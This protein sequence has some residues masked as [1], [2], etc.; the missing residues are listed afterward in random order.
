M[1]K[2]ETNATFIII[3]IAILVGSYGIG[4]CIREIN[5]SRTAKGETANLNKEMNSTSSADETQEIILPQD[6]NNRSR[7][8]G[9]TNTRNTNT[10]RN[11][12]MGRGMQNL[13]EEDMATMMEDFRNRGGIRGGQIDQ[14]GFGNRGG[15]GPDVSDS[16][17]DAGESDQQDD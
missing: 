3:C 9:M 14:S 11:T 8:M 12:R 1:K 5:N 15:S 13:S 10:G 2:A 7:N 16:D 6:R 4:F 17:S